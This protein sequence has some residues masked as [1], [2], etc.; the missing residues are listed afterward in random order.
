MKRLA[1][2]AL[3]AVALA[4]CALF[5]PGAAHQLE[6][7][8]TA[9]TPMTVDGVPVATSLE[10]RFPNLDEVVLDGPCGE[11]TT[12]L[13]LDTDGSAIGFGE[14]SDVSQPCTTAE[15]ADLDRVLGSIQHAEEWRVLSQDQIEIVSL[16]DD[17]VVA[18]E[19][20]ED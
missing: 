17:S 15:R 3:L 5:E 9:W 6:L 20:A 12:F 16:V 18:L 11:M 19:R 8:N 4:S 13:V 1:P 7:A 14:F 2:P 10:L